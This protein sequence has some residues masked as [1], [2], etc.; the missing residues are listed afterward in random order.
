MYRSLSEPIAS[1]YCEGQ[2][3]SPVA[4]GSPSVP[5]EGVA[6]TAGHL[7]GGRME[8][9]EAGRGRLCPGHLAAA[10]LFPHRWDL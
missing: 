1:F 5:G 7:P 10:L 4:P 2:R 8:M 9:T 6:L 3:E